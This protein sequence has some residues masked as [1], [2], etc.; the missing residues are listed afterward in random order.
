MHE[1]KYDMCGAAAVL[2][3]MRSV[4]QLKPKINVVCVVPSSENKTGAEAQ[5]PGDIVKALAF[6]AEAMYRLLQRF[7][8]GQTGPGPLLTSGWWDPQK[9]VSQA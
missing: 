7:G 1:M 3:A 4:C 2:G 6:G 8:E 5:V 9:A